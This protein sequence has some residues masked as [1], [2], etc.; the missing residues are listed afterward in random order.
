MAIL[1]L[2]QLEKNVILARL[3]EPPHPCT[4]DALPSCFTMILMSLPAEGDPEK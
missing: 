2:P 1:D 4:A 3:P